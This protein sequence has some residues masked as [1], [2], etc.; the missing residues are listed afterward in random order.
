V[1]ELFAIRKSSVEGAID[2]QNF[3]V[4]FG[5]KQI[6]KRCCK[7]DVDHYNAIPS[8]NIDCQLQVL[9]SGLLLIVRRLLSFSQCPEAFNEIKL[10]EV[11]GVT[12][13]AV[14]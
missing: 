5:P 1:R 10:R 8:L 6:R 2:Q 13:A 11:W 12:R 4:D 14:A 7:N 9:I 3:V